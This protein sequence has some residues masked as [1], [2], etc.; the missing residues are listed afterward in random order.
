MSDMHKRLKQY[1]V[2]AGGRLSKVVEFSKGEAEIYVRNFIETHLSH[3][4]L[5]RAGGLADIVGY[6]TDVPAMKDKLTKEADAIMK[7]INNEIQNISGDIENGIQGLQDNVKNEL[8]EMLEEA[9]GKAA[10]AKTNIK[11]IKDGADFNKENIDQA[12]DYLE[13]SL[14][15]VKEYMEKWETDPDLSG[16]MSGGDESGGNAS[17]EITFK[18]EDENNASRPDEEE[19]PEADE[20]QQ[21]VNTGLNKLR[22][23]QFDKFEEEFSAEI[24]AG[25]YHEYKYAKEKE[26][27]CEQLT[28]ALKSLGADIELDPEEYWVQGTELV[29][30]EDHGTT[31]KWFRTKD[32]FP[33]EGEA[34]FHYRDQATGKWYVWQDDEYV[35][36]NYAPAVINI[37]QDIRDVLTAANISYRRINIDWH[38]KNYDL[39]EG[40]SYDY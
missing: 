7:G 18:I 40:F 24:Y 3:A 31:T 12:K 26:E 17:H 39:D 28:T 1:S 37:E 11:D 13:E 14:N 15:K 4:V 16:F 34:G 9:K 38:D 6:F 22:K 27:L 10:L 23:W 36:E 20:M 35:E 2:I 29:R 33:D 5:Q 21:T 25:S 32:E 19:T 8:T 30:A